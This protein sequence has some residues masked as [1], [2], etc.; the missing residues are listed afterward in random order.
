MAETDVLLKGCDSCLGDVFSASELIPVGKDE[1]SEAVDVALGYDFPTRNQLQDAGDIYN[2]L[3]TWILIYEIVYPGLVIAYHVGEGG[4][5][6]KLF[7]GLDEGFAK[8]EGVG[9]E[10]EAL[11]GSWLTLI[12]VGDNRTVE[13]V[14]AKDDMVGLEVL[15]ELEGD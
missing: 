1:L 5:G 9:K 8:V 10:P 2:T 14:T 11:Y 12:V 3:Q 4:L 13:S 7:E 15:D 6:A